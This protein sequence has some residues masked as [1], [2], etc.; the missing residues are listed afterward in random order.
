MPSE[1][2]LEITN[3]ERDQLAKS[4]LRAMG[5]LFFEYFKMGKCGAVIQWNTRDR[6]LELVDTT[7]VHFGSEHA[8]ALLRALDCAHAAGRRSLDK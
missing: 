6:H 7:H 4:I 5:E 8:A 2:R 1:L 3:H